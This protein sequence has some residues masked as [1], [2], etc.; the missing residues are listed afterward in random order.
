M[1]YW[2]N[3]DAVGWFARDVLPALRRHRPALRFW[4][5]G[6]NP[7]AAVQALAALPGVHV[8]G[9]VADMRPYSRHADV[10][11]APL[12]IARGI[13]NKVLEAMAMGG[14][15]WPRRRPS[16]ACMPSPAATCWWPTVPRKRRG[17]SA[18]C[19]TAATPE[20]GAAAR[21]AVERGHA[22]E[23]TLAPA[24]RLFAPERMPCGGRWERR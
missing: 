15:W 18:R 10:V 3:V 5:V 4:I 2:P 6:A 13:Q 12:R 1:D 14:R 19:W 16:R 24:G 17:W 8:T 7:A 22:W 20:L 11:V 9:R 23:A 21:A